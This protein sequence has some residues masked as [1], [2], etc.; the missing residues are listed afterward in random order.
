MGKHAKNKPLLELTEAQIQR[1]CLEYLN[2]NGFYAFRYNSGLVRVIRN[3]N[4]TGMVKLGEAGMPDILALRD[5]QFYG[6]EIKRMGKKSTTIQTL[7]QKKLTNFGAKVY[8]IHSLDEL[9]EDLKAILI[10]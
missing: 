3:R 5:G 7:T 1:Q 2:Y 10:K 4:Q 6:F 8:E 9:H